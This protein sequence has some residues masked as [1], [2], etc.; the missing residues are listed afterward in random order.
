MEL[1]SNNLKE[2]GLECDTG[3]FLCKTEMEYSGFWVTCDSV[4]PIDK[5]R[6][7]EWYDTTNFLEGSLQVHGL[8]ELI[9]W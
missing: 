8:S 9:S 4:K 6:I 3:F 7:N 1:D 2:S 5:N